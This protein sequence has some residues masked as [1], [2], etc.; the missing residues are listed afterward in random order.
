MDLIEISVVSTP[1]N[2]STL[3]TL[4]KSIKSFFEEIQENNLI[5]NNNIMEKEIIEQEVKEEVIEE[6]K[7]VEEEIIE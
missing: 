6:I 1:A 7:E 2:A 5:D 3:F 4:S